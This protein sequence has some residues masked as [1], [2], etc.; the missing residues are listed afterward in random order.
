MQ[1]AR[2]DTSKWTL[3]DML[4]NSYELNYRLF[5]WQNALLTMTQKKGITEKNIVAYIVVCIYAF[6][7][8]LTRPEPQS[9]SYLKIIIL[10]APVTIT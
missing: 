10:F 7:F 4:F 3:K 6:L 2:C 8:Y 1:H 9:R 5:T